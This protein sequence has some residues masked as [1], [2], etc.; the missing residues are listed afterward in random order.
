MLDRYSGWLELLDEAGNI[1]ATK[2]QKQ[3]DIAAYG[4]DRLFAEI[5]MYRNDRYIT[6]HPY[7]VEGPNGERYVLLWKTPELNDKMLLAVGIFAASLLVFLMGA[8]FF[9]TRYSVRQLKKPL[10]QIAQGIGEMERFHYEKRLHFEAE[11]EFAEIRDAFND[12]AERLQLASAAKATAEK[13]KQNLLLHLS[14]DL[15]RRLR[16]YWVIPNCC[17]T[18]AGGRK[19]SA[20]ICPIHSR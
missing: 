20:E 13:N 4:G 2:G 5:D 16:R 9:Y 3:D 18:T 15:K 7:S 8:L 14:H 6:Y 1:I 12:M 17:W 11:Q 19:G 10:Q